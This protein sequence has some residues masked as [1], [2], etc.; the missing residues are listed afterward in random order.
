[1]RR[2]VGTSIPKIDAEDKLKGKARYA[3]DRSAPDMLWVKVARSRVPRARILG[4]DIGPAL[5]LSGVRGVYT[6]EDIPGSNRAGPRIKD[7][8]LLCEDTVQA[9]GD[10]IAI[11]AADSKEAAEEAVGCVEIQLQELTPIT[12]IEEAMDPDAPVIREGGNLVKVRSIITG[13]ADEAL[14]SA[15]I[16][17]SN[18]YRTQM[19]EHAYMEPEAAFA[20][21]EDGK[22]TVWMPTKYIN[23]DHGELAA[24]L[25]LEPEDLR[26]VLSTVGG[27]FGGKSGI[28]PAYYCALVTYLTGRPSKMAYTREE[29]FLSSTKRHPTLIEHT[30]GADKDGK[31]VAAKIR[32]LADA[33]AYTGFSPSVLS[34]SAVHAAG[35]Y[36][37]PNISVEACLVY[38]NT[39]NA[40]A[41]RG[42]GVPQTA[43]AHEAQMDLLAARLDMDPVAVRKMNFL[44]EGSQTITGQRLKHS[45]GLE[46]TCDEVVR[47]IQEE[48]D[49]PD[50]NDEQYLYGWGLA[51]M[52]YGIGST[53][54]PNPARVTLECL[55]DGTVKLLAG[56][57]DGGQGAATALSQ[58]VAESL[59]MPVEKIRFT[60]PATDVTPDSGTSTASRLTYVVGRALCEAGSTLR[61]EW[62]S[63][64][65]RLLG[66]SAETVR[67][68]EGYFYAEGDDKIA[69]SDLLHRAAAEGVCLSA[70]GYF[71]PD[72]TRLDPDSG[73][74]V[75]YGTYAFAT[76][77]AL[78]RVD[79]GTG[80]VEV[81]KVIA[82]HDVGNAVNPKMVEAQLQGGVVMGVGY[83]IMEQV[84][85]EKGKI[86]NPG[87]HGYLIPTALDIPDIETIIVEHPEPTGPYG[88]KG[89][90]E[91]ALIP[92]APAVCSA[93][94]SATGCPFFEIPLTAERVWHVLSRG[95]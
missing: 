85:L 56:I 73:H 55:K 20:A 43:F 36:E 53:G 72:T 94:T 82:A 40:G 65:G 44:K 48:G 4:I 80:Q 28:S 22:L 77:G 49:A 63:Y 30:L 47:R 42:F 16:V 70:H 7:E 89:V 8:V 9:V 59:Q 68:E 11:V 33:G 81:L 3:E 15:D 25:D 76:Q 83:G 66:C 12:S 14:E 31:L 10:P 88:A 93:V 54:I 64:A 19:I 79:R 34:R 52:F 46:K 86:L 60:T 29:S 90:G 17:I 41:M 37:V 61:E 27:Y 84:I 2:T 5:A 26:L 32:I 23:A 21:Y 71:D 87:F 69:V 13:R 35:P 92:T 67:F 39:V 57:T 6:A 75:P 38:T 51:S 95:E 74:G 91:P 50:R 45:V 24:I 1:M 58:I 18:T 62:K 78:V